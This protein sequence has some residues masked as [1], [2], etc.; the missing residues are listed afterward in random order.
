MEN[1]NPKVFLIVEKG[2]PFH[3]GDIINLIKC[4]VLIGR[5][6]ERIAAQ[7]N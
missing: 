7:W 3:K 6:W 1:L 4:P 2:E 5:D